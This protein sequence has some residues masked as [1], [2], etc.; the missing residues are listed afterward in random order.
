MLT[1]VDL[2]AGAGGWTSGLRRAGLDHIVGVEWDAKAAA[3]YE[4]NHGEGSV[5]VGDVCKIGA[6][7]VQPHLRGRKVDVLVASPPCQSFSPLSGLRYAN[8]QAADSLYLEVVRIAEQLQPEWVVVENVIGFI[9]KPITPGGITAAE[10]LIARLKRTGYGTVTMGMIR[11]EELGVPQMRHRVLVVA[12]RSPGL[13]PLPTPE[14]GAAPASHLRALLE[15]ASRVTNKF[16]WMTPEKVAYYEA[17]EARMPGRVRFLDVDRIAFTVRASYYKSRGAE[18][19]L[20]QDGRVRMLTET[21][22]ARIQTFPDNYTFLGSHG[23]CCKQIGNAVPPLLA[24]HVG[25]ALLHAD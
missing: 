23:D 21:E 6:A 18:A 11:T 22:L 3:S 17:R 19:L 5:I 20:R 24:Y 16:Y 2:F 4:A 7:E 25:K 12:R 8:K 10:D 9:N 13:A 1:F 15:P 14:P